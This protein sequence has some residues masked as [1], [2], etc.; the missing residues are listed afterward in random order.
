MVTNGTGSTLLVLAL[1]LQALS[2]V[3]ALPPA[4]QQNVSVPL[5]A[6][7]NDYDISMD[8]TAELAGIIDVSEE[9]ARLR[10][11]VW[12]FEQTF[13]VKQ[14]FGSRLVEYERNVAERT[15]QEVG[16]N[17]AEVTGA[18]EAVAANNAQLVAQGNIAFEQRDR[19]LRQT[20]RE[21]FDGYRAHLAMEMQGDIP[22]HVEARTVD[23]C[24]FFRGQFN[25]GARWVERHARE[26]CEM[27]AVALREEAHR[28][29]I[30]DKGSSASR[31]A[32]VQEE[33]VRARH[34]EECSVGLWKTE[35][36]NAR[37]QAATEQE[38]AVARCR[39][40]AAA[41]LD[42]ARAHAEH[43]CE[44][45]E[46]GFA[47]ERDRAAVADLVLADMASQLRDEQAMVSEL[48]DTALGMQSQVDEF[49]EQY[50][51]STKR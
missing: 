30:S 21:E 16:A 51:K 22:A 49:V 13:E 42:N 12:R 9:E 4:S 5:P 15:W 39:S 40:S 1:R 44:R 7:G 18:L 41:A 29:L 33:L 19:A 38:V 26:H 45:F 23:V 10:A 8:L 48:R 6:P 17:R 34:G 28:E 2:D 24:D 11:Q 3:A 31:Q 14:H 43:H 46:E 32:R 25:E 36:A 50:A 35:M 27:F 20:V 47:R 37:V